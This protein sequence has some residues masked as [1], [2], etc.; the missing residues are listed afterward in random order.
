M[1]SLVANMTLAEIDAELQQ[2]ESTRL[3]DRTLDMVDRIDLLRSAAR[4]IRGGGR[5]GSRQ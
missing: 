4:T 3:C 1:R 5:W 2:L